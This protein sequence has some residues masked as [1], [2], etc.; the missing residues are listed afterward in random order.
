MCD[1]EQA[2][3]TFLSVKK[4]LKL[5]INTEKRLRDSTKTMRVQRILKITHYQ[6][7]PRG[8]ALATLNRCVNKTSV[9]FGAKARRQRK[10]N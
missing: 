1:I 3:V 7:P 4:R 5:K 2:W 10:C 8:V 6:N 9:R